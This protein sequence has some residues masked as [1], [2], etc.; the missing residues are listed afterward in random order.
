MF[1]YKIV[2]ITSR[3]EGFL[4]TTDRKLISDV[5]VYGVFIDDD[6]VEHPAEITEIR[7]VQK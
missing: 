7:P 5:L 6:G 4:V 1:E 3:G 2:F